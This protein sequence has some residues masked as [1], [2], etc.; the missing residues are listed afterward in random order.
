M[1]LI[2]IHAS[3]RKTVIYHPSLADV[4]NRALC[5][6]GRHDYETVLEYPSIGAKEDMCV[7]C[8]KARYS[9]HALAA[10]SRPVNR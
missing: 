9:V 10:A 5:L 4:W 7:H 6:A 8:M 1:R 3:A 2:R